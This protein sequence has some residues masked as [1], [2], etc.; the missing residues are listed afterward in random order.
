MSPRT[1]SATSWP[2]VA[3][4]VSRLA[5]LLV[6][7]MDG[8]ADQAAP[9]G[10]VV[11]YE[12]WAR[13]ASH[14]GVLPWH[15]PGW[16]YPGGALPVLL[17]PGLA[18]WHGDYLIGFILEMLAF[19]LLALVALMSLGR[20]PGWDLS[21]A[22]LWVLT[23]PALGPLALGRFDI[24]PAS[25]TVCVLVL[26]S[27]HPGRA[28][29]LLGLA[30]LVKLWPG[31]LIAALWRHS[32]AV[33]AAT[34]T[35]LAALLAAGVVV[36]W[37]GFSAAFAFQQDRGLQQESLAALPF[38]ALRAIN[39]ADYRVVWDHGAYEIVGPGTA[40]AAVACTI[41]L[42]LAAC[43]VALFTRRVPGEHLFALIAAF[44]TAVVLIDKVLS[45]QYLLW[46]AAPLAVWASTTGRRRRGVALAFLASCGV[47]QPLATFGY[48]ALRE[49][50][51]PPV[52]ALAAR[53]ALLLLTALLLVQSTK[54][55]LSAD[56]IDSTRP[57][58][59]LPVGAPAAH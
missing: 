11:N 13:A 4:V 56:R 41:A 44:V 20:R 52:V 42:V 48:R 3:W 24:V 18:G 55:S 14:D 51:W 7:V 25:L 39:V 54:R 37:A 8:M 53:D 43:L 58:G 33:A 1:L 6:G 9:F 17:L 22:W 21:G 5:M 32:R 34:V 15:E 47:T 36:G 35:S 10:D 29:V 26:L 27:R 57:I 49:G 46:V 19:D 30:T 31:L 40:A 2:V 45:P 23:L 50:D 12:G 38:M 28:G 16:A 59:H